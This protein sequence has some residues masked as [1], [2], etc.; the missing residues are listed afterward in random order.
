MIS[1]DEAEVGCGNTRSIT[2]NFRAILPLQR[3]RKSTSNPAR[4]RYGTVAET[5][6]SILRGGT[7][8]FTIGGNARRISPDGRI[9][10]LSDLQNPKHPPFS[11]PDLDD[12]DGE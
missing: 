7:P 2:H 1:A 11:A 8:K 6:Q 5:V 12:D 3:I 9:V 4:E 10:S